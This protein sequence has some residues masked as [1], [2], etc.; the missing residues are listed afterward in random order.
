LALILL[1]ERIDAGPTAGDGVCTLRAKDIQR[2]AR[3][4]LGVSVGLGSVYRTLERMGSSCM[5][6]C[7]PR[8]E[9]QD[10]AAQK[11]FKDTAAP[12]C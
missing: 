11:A 10:L 1:K 6:P 2:I 3:N 5:A 12:L 9:K 4:E 8:H 7:R